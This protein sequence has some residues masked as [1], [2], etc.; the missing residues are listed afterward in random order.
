MLARRQFRVLF[1][2]LR[3]QRFGDGVFL[4]EPFAQINQPAALGTKGPEVGGEPITAL[5]ANGAA[6]VGQLAHFVS[7][8]RVLK[9]ATSLAVSSG[10]IPPA[11]R[12]F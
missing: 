1:Q 11:W 5:F 4:A 10:E 7:V 12:I 2:M 6:D 3:A 8:A 9:S